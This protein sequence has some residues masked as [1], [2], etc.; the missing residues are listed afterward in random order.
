MSTS[1]RQASARSNVSDLKQLAREI[2]QETLARIDIPSTMRQKLARTGSQ[3]RFDDT[4]IDLAA[5]DRIIAIAVG[6]ASVAMARGLAELLAGDFAFKGILVTPHESVTEVRGF[7][8]MGASHPIPDKGSIA[9]AGAIINLLSQCDW[10]TLLFFLLSGGGSSLIELPLDPNISLEDVRQLN[11]LLV[12]CGASINEIN[13]VRKHFSAVKGGRLAA[14]APASVKLTLAITDVPVG[15]ESALASG[16]TLPDPTTVSDACRVI[17]QYALDSKLPAPI[18][19]RCEHPESIPETPKRGDPAFSRARFS[20][21]L[22]MDDLFHHAHQAAEARGFVTQ[23]DNSTDDWPI[24]E[25]TKYLLGELDRL[26]N[27]NHGRRVALIADGEV[28]S[29]VRGDGVGG[30]NS[31]FVLDCVEKIA[32][33]QIAVLSAGTDGKD[34]SSPAAGAVAD[35][36][37]FEKALAANLRPQEFAARSDSYS[38]FEKLGDAIETGPTGNN[39][40]DL[41]ILLAE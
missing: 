38:F 23:C 33:K 16:P 40:R 32:G 4:L 15:Y 10:R 14:L 37:T 19:A 30:R 36:T 17:E 18:R 9:A 6:K 31:A 7:R 3:I 26:A 24:P 12:G 22:T 39:L 1:L 28:S 34:G 20:L 2:F 13:S 25:A 11:R 41:R 27:A 29:P 21:L 35:G 5:Y 8:A